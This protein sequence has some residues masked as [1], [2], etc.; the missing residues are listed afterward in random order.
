MQAA[1]PQDA[2]AAP[3]PSSV[4]VLRRGRSKGQPTYSDG[5]GPQP[6]TPVSTGKQGP[7]P[8]NPP[9]KPSVKSVSQVP[10]D[11]ASVEVTEATIP[12]AAHF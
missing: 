1:N 3:V 2:P 5:A 11:R 8:A 9:S 7:Q 12:G 6:A 4:L 10:D